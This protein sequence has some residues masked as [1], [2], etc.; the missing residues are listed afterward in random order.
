VAVVMVKVGS[1]FFTA[2]MIGRIRSNA[3]APISARTLKRNGPPECASL[4]LL[5]R[6]ASYGSC[7]GLVR[8]W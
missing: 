5:P 7:G 8:S 2:P 4:L 6:R 3:E 1:H